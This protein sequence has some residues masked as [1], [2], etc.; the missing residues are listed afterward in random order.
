MSVNRQDVVNSLLAAL[1]GAIPSAQEVL[2]YKPDDLAGKTPVI[3]LESLGSRFAPLT[4]LGVSAEFHFSINV[5][6]VRVDKESGWT[7][8]QAEQKLNEINEQVRTFIEV[9]GGN[10][11]AWASIGMA[12]RSTI[13]YFI[14]EGGT[15]YLLE[16]YPIIVTVYA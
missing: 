8:R 14:P 10:T 11:I 7:A 9:N 12:E 1:A 5:F 2:D 13:S 15:A 4:P 6:V 3:A 16:T